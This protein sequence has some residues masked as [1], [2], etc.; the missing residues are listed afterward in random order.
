MSP[1]ARRTTQSQICPALV[2][3][4]APVLQGGTGSLALTPPSGRGIIPVTV[5]P[6][7]PLE[8]PLFPALVAPP[9]LPLTPASP[10]GESSSSPQAKLAAANTTNHEAHNPARATRR[11]NID[12]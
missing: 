2:Q 8:P 3:G 5:A 1:A 6:L 12:R 9:P 7:E 4:V 11:R 10:F